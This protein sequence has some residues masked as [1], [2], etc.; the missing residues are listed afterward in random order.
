MAIMCHHFNMKTTQELLN[1]YKLKMSAYRH[2]KERLEKRIENAQQ[3]LAKHE[4]TYP[5]WTDLVKTICEAVAEHEHLLLDKDE[6]YLTF[7]CRACCPIF[8]HN[9]Q[10]ECVGDI[11]FTFRDTLYYDTGKKKFECDSTS[12]A[13]LNGFDNEEAPLPNTLEEI[14]EKC[15]YKRG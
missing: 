6:R 3:R 12:L 13:G 9:E 4:R 14:I 5:Y 7:G 1:D 10:G 2:E 8:F 11:S 15:L